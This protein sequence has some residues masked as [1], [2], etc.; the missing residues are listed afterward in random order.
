MDKEK[1]SRQQPIPD[2]LRQILNSKQHAALEMIQSLGWQL[3]F[4]RRP[5]FMEAQPVVY[6]AK[7]DQIG[8]LDVDGNIDLELELNIR[9]SEPEQ[10]PQPLN[11][12][13][14]EEKRK[15]MVPVPGNLDALLNQNQ[16]RALHQIETFGWQLHF[17]RRPLFQ[18]PVA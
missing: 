14:V 5:M 11:P 9:T 7:F 10:Q 17:V 13:P 2:N 16:L 1:R 15:G 18:E 12:H 6:N 4:V 8:V 3:K